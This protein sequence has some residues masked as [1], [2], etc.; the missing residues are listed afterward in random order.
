MTEEPHPRRPKLSDDLE[1]A[2]RSLPSKTRL[3]QARRERELLRVV[4]DA[5]GIINVSSKDFY[6]AHASLVEAMTEA[7]EATSTRVGARMDK[8]T[9]EATLKELDAHEK[10]KVITTSVRI[11][12]GAIRPVRIAYLP[13]TSE[14]ELQAFLGSISIQQF[15]PQAQIKTLD[16]PIAFGRTD[17]KRIVVRSSSITQ[18]R[19]S[20]VSIGPDASQAHVDPVQAA[21]LNDKSTV[22]QMFGFING[23]VAR[24]RAL[25]LWLVDFLQPG[26]TSAHI[27]SSRE[28]V[29]CFSSLLNDL[30]ISIYCAVVSSQTRNEELLQVLRSSQGQSTPVSE[31][32]SSIR[33]V[34]QIG[35]SRSHERLLDILEIL[36]RLNLVH[37]LV[38]SHSAIPAIVV[39]PI[40]GHPTAF[41]IAPVQTWTPLTGPAYFHLNTSAP[42]HLWALSEDSPPRWKTV[43]VYPAPECHEYWAQLQLVSQDREAAKQIPSTELGEP[44]AGAGEIGRIIRRTSSWSSS[45]VIS[46]TQEAF[47]KQHIDLTS[48]ATPLQDEDGA[49]LDALSATIFAPREAIMRY[50]DNWRDKIMRD[51]ARVAKKAERIAEE[52]RTKEA[53][54]KATMAQ[55]AAEAKAQRERDWEDMV[56]K[57][58]P[59]P[60]TDSAATRIRRIRGKFLQSSGKN[61]EKWEGEI[62]EAIQESIFAAKQVLAA[63]RVPLAK[64][65]ATPAPLPPVATTALEKSV[66]ELIESQGPRL[67]PRQPVRKSKKGKEPQDGGSMFFT[68]AYHVIYLLCR[69]HAKRACKTT[70]VSMDQRL[71]RVGSR[72]FRHRQG[73][74]PWASQNRPRCAVPS[75]PGC[76]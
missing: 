76:A 73:S 41:D 55:R 24:A 22:A 42:L 69:G 19:E 12:T 5:G 62:A 72:R 4:N 9:A 2:D 31:L 65:A 47:L 25:H 18:L 37:P 54:S 27:I 66:R 52:A 34:L 20:T 21:V 59:G 16:E 56:A 13:E 28:R 29:T 45:Y 48:G 44:L 39:D 3:V 33:D 32:P 30:P 57:V 6:E 43:A 68:L 70:K 26:A 75:L 71:R 38:P 46:S 35:R 8:R 23:K 60:L 61:R 64:P 7:G 74:L 51:K 17:L 67:A 11:S 1:H 50:Y 58:H 36:C 40:P 14:A 10:V 63:N 49:R 53:R 15:P